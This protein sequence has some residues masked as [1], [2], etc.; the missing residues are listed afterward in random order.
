MNYFEN[1][2]IDSINFNFL[3]VTTVAKRK[4]VYDG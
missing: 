4:H 3:F 1:I 2:Q